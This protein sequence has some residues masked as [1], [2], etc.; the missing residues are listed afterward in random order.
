[1]ASTPPLVLPRTVPAS[2]STP[3]EVP[4]GAYRRAQA[5]PLQARDFDRAGR[6]WEETYPLVSARRIDHMEWFTRLQWFRARAKFFWVDHPLLRGSGIPI[7]GQG[8]ENLVR[9]AAMDTEDGATGVV[10]SFDS[11][12]TGTGWTF[13]VNGTAGAQTITADGTG[14]SGDEAEARQVILRVYP[15]DQV[16]GSFDARLQTPT[17]LEGGVRIE[18]LNEADTEVG[19]PVETTFSATAFARVVATGTAPDDAAY[20]RIIALARLTANSGSGDAEFR[21]AAFVR[22]GT[23]VTPWVNPHVDGGSQTGD[24][25]NT[26]GWPASTRVLEPGDCFRIGGSAETKAAAETDEV[27][28]SFKVL[29]PVDSDGSGLATIPIDPPI[30]SG[31]TISGGAALR[32]E[33]M[34]LR[35]GMIGGDLRRPSSQV[36]H[37][38]GLKA[39]FAE[40]I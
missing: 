27:V 35:V 9:D 3:D 5:G 14:S 39:Q 2:Q 33:K 17:D 16:T 40:A 20:A 34:R 24:T 31:L 4:P 30:F 1:M 32:F 29:A 13:S 37:F 38:G 6:A 10:L 7:K 19:T 23:D 36:H 21:D 26:A 12:T 25:L 8:R 18:W 28:R 11:A 22:A 15:G